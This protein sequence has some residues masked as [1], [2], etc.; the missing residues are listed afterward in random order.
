M[1]G[2]PGTPLRRILEE[3]VPKRA[4]VASLKFVS[5]SGG[6]TEF[7]KD[8]KH[9]PVQRHNITQSLKTRISGCINKAEF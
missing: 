5:S 3:E 2:F 4:I 6:T 1:I 9:D 8:T 7:E